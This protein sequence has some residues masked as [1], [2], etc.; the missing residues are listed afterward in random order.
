MSLSELLGV[1]VL[2][3]DGAVGGRVREVAVAPQEDAARVAG[4]IVRTASG[5]RMLASAALAA[6]SGTTVRAAAPV[7]EWPAFAGGE[8]LLLLERDLLDQQIIDVHGRKVVRVNDVDLHPEPVNGYVVLRI[9]E[10][11][12]GA[13]G[14]VRR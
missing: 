8:G 2:D 1:P 4:L 13:R 6:V 12:V 9:G 10:V 11:D 7:A 5:D 14:A 3:S